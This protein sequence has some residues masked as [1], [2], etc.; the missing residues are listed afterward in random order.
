MNIFFMPSKINEDDSRCGEH[1]KKNQCCDPILNVDPH[2][3]QL[4]DTISEGYK[5]KPHYV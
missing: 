1:K 3:N 5:D 2:Y 4:Y